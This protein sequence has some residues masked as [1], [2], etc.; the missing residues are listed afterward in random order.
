M[1]SSGSRLVSRLMLLI[2]LI[3]LV[4]ITAGCQTR[5][6]DIPYDVSNFG[7][8]DGP[9]PVAVSTSYRAAVQDVL[10]VTVFRVPSLSGEFTVDSDGTLTMPLI[11][12]VPA[13]GLTID[14]L[15]AS[16]TQRLAKSYL[17]NPSVTVTVKS[18][19]SMR[20]TV[21][22]SVRQPGIYPI[23]G[24]TSL[25]QAISQARGLDE[26]ANAKR[27]YIFRQI[28]GKRMAA[29]FDLTDIRR[30]AAP[31]PPVYRDDIIVVDGSGSRKFFRDIIST[32]PV[33]GVFRPF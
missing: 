12:A 2:G 18:A 17:N 31:D 6:D 30:G 8:P 33:L 13:V 24:Q 10:N 20:V 11:G 32:I 28:D 19:P 23:S 7:M 16:I 4:G 25:I 22:G 1:M 9:A 27:V 3:G 29:A 14:E 5:G 21:D 15:Q 26:N